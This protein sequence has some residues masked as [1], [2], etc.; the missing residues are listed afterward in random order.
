MNANGGNMARKGLRRTAL[1]A[2]T[3]LDAGDDLRI[4][5]KPFWAILHVEPNLKVAFPSGL[6]V[7][8]HNEV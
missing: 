7:I 6:E 2:D 1:S 3:K 8:S 5:L 4:P